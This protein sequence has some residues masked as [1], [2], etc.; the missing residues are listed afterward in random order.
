MLVADAS[1]TVAALTAAG[2]ISEQ[3]RAALTAADDAAAPAILDVE[4]ISALRGL[5]RGGKLE[6]TAADLAVAELG[7]FPVRRFD[8]IPLG[9]RIWELRHN[10]TAYDAAYVALAEAFHATVLTSDARLAKA[11]G[12]RCAFQVLG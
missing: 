2:P 6:P 8:L 10:L 11:D 7:S 4:V 1:A 9:L 12:P 3:A 5:V